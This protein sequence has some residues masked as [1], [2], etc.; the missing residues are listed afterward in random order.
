MS[1][2]TLTVG[3]DLGMLAFVKDEISQWVDKTAGVS[4]EHSYANDE[5]LAAFNILS[6]KDASRLCD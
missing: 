2:E 6:Y 4:A 3:L 5:M 1:G